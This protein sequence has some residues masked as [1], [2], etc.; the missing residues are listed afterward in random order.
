MSEMIINSKQSLEA[1]KTFLDAQFDQHKYLRP[2]LK[3]G[4]QRTSTQNASLHLFCD[5]LA[6]ALNDAGFDFRAFVKEGYAVPFTD[7]L[8]KDYI[9]RPIQ[10]AI[11]GKESTTKPETHQYALIYDAVNTKLVEHG[12]YVPWPSKDTMNI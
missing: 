2:S 6:N 10:K 8:V 4:K 11:T 9:W 1:Y 5:M 7:D 12:I 3:T